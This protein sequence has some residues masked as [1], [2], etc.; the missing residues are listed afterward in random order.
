MKKVAI[1]FLMMALAATAWGGPSKKIIDAGGSGP[2]K[3]EAIMEPTLVDFTVYKPADLQAAVT[4]NGPLP[5]IVFANGACNDTSLPYERM[6]NDLASYGYL[7][8]ALGEMQDSINDRELHKSPTEDM[9]RAID[10]AEKQNKD[11]RSP[12]Y[13]KIDMEYVGLAGQSC[14]GAQVLANCADPRVKTCIMFNSGMGDMEMA[15]AS[16]ESLKKLHCPILYIVGGESDIAYLNALSDY[17]K[18]DNVPVAFANQLRVGHGGT[19]HEEYGGSF[20]RLLRAWLSWQ[21]KDQR[22]NIEVFLRNRV[23]D[24]PDY[25]MK[26]KNFPDVNE[27]FTVKEIHCKA[28]DGKDIW[29][30]LYM[31]ATQEKQMPIVIMA[32][33]YNGTHYEPKP[34][35][36]SLAMR[37]VASYIFDFC[38]GSN[39]SKS[40]GETTEMTIFTEKGNVED[41]TAMVKSWDFV[42]PSRVSLLGCSQGGLVAGLTAAANPEAYKSLILVYP[43][44]TIPATAPMMLQRFDADGG[45]PQEVM[46]M[47]LGRDYYEAI[48]GMDALDSI[49]AYKG[50]VFIVYGDKDMI[51]AGGVDKAIEKYEKCKTQVIAG[52]DHGF[53]NYR[54][55]EE[56]TEGIVDFAVT[57]LS[58]PRGRWHHEFDPSNPDVHDPVM[59]A[60]NGKYYMFTTGMG[61]GMMSSDDMKTWKLEKQVLDPIPEWAMEPVPAYKGHTWAP[62][63]IKVGDKWYLYYSCSTFG[64]NI[65]AI[66]VAT[67]KTLDPQSPDYKWED[68]GMVIMSQPGVTDWNAIDPNVIIDKKGNP[69]LTFGSFWDGIQLVQL[70]KDMKTPKG[71][72]VTIARRRNPDSVAHWQPTANTNAIEAP[73]ITYKDGYYYL[74]VSYDYCCKGIN[75]NYKTAVGRSKN[76]AGPY[77]DKDGKDMASTGGT[78]LVA[79]GP[80]YSGVGHCSVY[81]F[82]GKWYIA[83]HGYDK[84][85]NGASKLYLR[86]IDWKDGWPEIVD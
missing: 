11:S 41:I 33:G 77:L 38:G 72:P 10:W 82:G 84:R 44:F 57:T 52:A 61:V 34:F 17:D 12:Y 23:K 15:G 54:H 5:L 1:S 31:P 19:F 24:F 40:D 22:N 20:S 70:E 80:D 69:W 59:A 7:V 39:N 30:E 8:V 86:E 66:G 73:F 27:P 16:K 13:K 71:K 78:I 83:A 37:G 6:L 63:I 43:A 14:G 51:V 64:K 18:I 45:K 26:A 29:G 55:H 36:E 79:E 56:A 62:D 2:N 58:K 4:E 32:H 68:Q 25:T 65:S 67:N 42:D 48:N 74:F 60:E 3:A 9:V 76:V 53:S 28:R 35:A 75:S 47:K 21:F 81:D 46:G 50:D 85:R 49:G